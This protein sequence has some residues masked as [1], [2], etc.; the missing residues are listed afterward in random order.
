MSSK[1]FIRQY[2]LIITLNS[3]ET[4]KILPEIRIQFEVNKSI[5]GGLNTCTIKIYNLNQDKQMKLVREKE[6]NKSRLPFILKAG[7]NKLETIFKGTIFEAKTTKTGSDFITT[8]TSQD[9]GFDFINSFTSKTVK[10]NDISNILEDMPNT[11]KGRISKRQDLIRPKVLVGNSAKLIEDS[12]AEDETYFIDDEKLYI[13]KD[14]E[15]ISPYIPLI[16]ANTGLLNTPTRNA[17]EVTFN[18]LMNPDL[19]IGGLVE[20]KSKY[21]IYLNGIYKI[22]TIKYKGDNYGS[23]WQQECLCTI[24]QDYKVI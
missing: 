8:I 22:K 20:L 1:K 19:R 12:L 14:T 7:Y 2:E 10:S 6:D 17:Y 15:V 4:V 13:I 11:Q 23:E 16:Q 5:K 18:V 3:K 24:A 21:A 9:G